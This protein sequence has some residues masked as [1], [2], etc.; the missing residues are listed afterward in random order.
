MNTG[1]IL[2]ILLLVGTVGTV[3][4]TSPSSQKGGNVGTRRHHKAGKKSRRHH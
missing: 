4:F 2:A 1:D 3:F